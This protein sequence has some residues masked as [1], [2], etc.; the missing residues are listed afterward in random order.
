MGTDGN[1]RRLPAPWITLILAA[2]LATVALVVR[3]VSQ[4]READA[5]SEGLRA[6]M[7]VFSLLIAVLLTIVMAGGIVGYFRARM[8]GGVRRLRAKF[9][10]AVVTVVVVYQSERPALEYHAL[11]L[12]E[13]PRLPANLVLVVDDEQVT[14]WLGRKPRQVAQFHPPLVFRA[15][16]VAGPTR[17][18]SGASLEYSAYKDP[19]RIAFIPIREIDG[20]VPK[21]F[22]AD[23]LTNLIETLNHRVG[24]ST[25]RSI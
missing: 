7:V 21:Q 20:L 4:L 6:E 3:V 16:E 14:M 1:K 9:P 2:V 8:V 5:P 18:V 10:G 23:G 25:R 17:T 19:R 13:V 15:S 22:T 12:E 11:R 24:T